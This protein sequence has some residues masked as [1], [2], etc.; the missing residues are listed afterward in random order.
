MNTAEPFAELPVAP[1]P[2]LRRFHQARWDEPMIFE[3]SRPGRRGIAV[4]E[5]GAPRVEL[6]ESVRR[7]EP[8][9]LPE[10]AQPHVV[11]HYLRLSQENLGNDLNIDVG[12]GTCT[13]KYS[14]KVNDRFAA[15]VAE[16][17]PLQHEDTVQGVLEIYW[18]M[19]RMLAEISGMSRVSLQPAS[20]SA[21]IYANIAMI[22]AYHAARGETH[23]DQVITT[24][25]SHP[26]N[27]ACAKVAGFEVITLMPDADGLP[28][29]EALRAAVGPR[30][31]ALMITNPEDT[32]IFNP[33]IREFVDLVHEAGGLACYDQA[34]AN[35][36]LGITRAR[37]AGFDLCHFNLHKTFSTPHSCG[38][39]A[40]GACGVS[41]DLAPFLPGPVVVFDGSAY[42]LETP[43]RSIGKV[44]PFLGV[45]QNIVRAYAWIMSLGAEGLR[46][47]AETA[48][49]NN[50]YLMRKI[51]AIPGASAPWGTRRIEQARYSWQELAEETGVHSEEIGVRAA[52]F[53]VHY[54]TSHHPYLV[55]E[56]FT[57]EPTES[58]SKEDLDEYAAIL[59]HV[60]DEARRD[61]EMVK[62]APYN[63]SVH[64]I[65]PSPLDDPKA[66]APTW[67][68][69][70]R[71]HLS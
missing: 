14:P 21:A 71:K 32:G 22:R 67:R 34:N 57:L 29:I 2:P 19:E 70:V 69:Y 52:D 64:K 51:L 27:A 18:R 63:Q 37:D 6:P 40:A 44:R 56:P 66:W 4:P 1:K 42:R 55:P 36:I 39:P 3:L 16:L 59:A 61:P 9:K 60:A 33:R 12:Q 8:P 13:M 46:Q 65:D 30:T 17:H 68:A 43:E 49:L 53:G 62:G 15:A 54:W 50:N 35:G 48:A 5:P 31:A 28:D 25:F 47:V 41:A 38:G 7:A 24:I 58:Y 26:S 23:R 10:L 20:G 11:R 45:T